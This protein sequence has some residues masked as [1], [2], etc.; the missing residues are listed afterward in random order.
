MTSLQ[1]EIAEVIAGSSQAGAQAQSWAVIDLLGLTMREHRCTPLC[2]SNC[3]DLGRTEVVG[4]A[5]SNTVAE[6][7]EQLYGDEPDV[8]ESAL[9]ALFAHGYADVRG[10][11][12]TTGELL[13]RDLVTN[14]RHRS[15]SDGARAALLSHGYLA[16]DFAEVLDDNPH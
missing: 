11:D 13:G 8:D 1:D 10:S 3:T 9:I 5:P 7:G 4:M 14:L 6:T 12:Q 15:W 16:A 2:P